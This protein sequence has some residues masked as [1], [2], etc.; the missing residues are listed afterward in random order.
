MGKNRSS[1][2]CPY[3]CSVGTTNSPLPPLLPCCTFPKQSALPSPASSKTP[4][5]VSLSCLLV[6]V[7]SHWRWWCREVPPLPLSNQHVL[8]KCFYRY[9]GQWA[10]TYVVV[11]NTAR[12]PS[13]LPMTTEPSGPKVVSTGLVSTTA[14]RSQQ[15]CLQSV[16]RIHDTS[17]RK[18]LWNSRTQYSMKC[19]NCCQPPWILKG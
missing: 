5:Q 16:V 13:T 12:I 4:L 10:N 2:W 17:E 3:R 19:F 8:C 11:P 14:S 18:V 9:E 7:D 1:P 6:W 15:F